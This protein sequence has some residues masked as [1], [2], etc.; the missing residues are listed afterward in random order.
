MSPTTILVLLAPVGHTSNNNRRAAVVEASRDDE[1]CVRLLAALLLAAD[2]YF[3]FKMLM[4][5]NINCLLL[6]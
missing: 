5:K 3:N 4:I 2:H 6:S 1:W